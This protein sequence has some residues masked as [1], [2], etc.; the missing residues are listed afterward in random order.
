MTG[1]DRRRRARPLVAARALRQL[2]ANPEDTVRVF[3]VINAMAG[4]ALARGLERFRRTELGRRVLAERLDLLD[5]LRD[6]EKLRTLPEGTLGRAYHDFVYGESLTADGLVAA[7]TNETVRTYG[8]DDPDLARFGARMRDQHDLLHTLTRYG[9]DPFGEVC[10][11]AFSYAQLRN[12]GIGMIVL[13]GAWWIGRRLGFGVVRAL[14]Q[15]YRAGQRAIWLPG[16]DWEALLRMPLAD[17]R[18][19]LGIREPS[20]YLEVRPAELPAMA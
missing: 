3:E 5:L 12:R 19:H 7:S 14:W 16:Q 17:V 20:V 10:L 4:P 15:A 18:R 6:R 13:V 1:A 2:V 8:F 11:L 9:R